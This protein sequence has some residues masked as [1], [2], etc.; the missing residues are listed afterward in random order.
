M[1]KQSTEQWLME[2]KILWIQ[3]IMEELRQPVE[4]PM[5]LYCDNNAAIIIA[6]NPVHHDWTKH[7]EIDRHFN[8]KKLE[9]GIICM[10]FVPTTQQTT[11]I[12]TKGLF[13]PNFELL[14][15]KLGMKDIYAPTWGGVSEK[16]S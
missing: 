11:C 4:A 7:V 5:K 3:R 13:K 15:G 10:P 14:I 8:K 12:L 9:V 1:P 16:S 2:C 6:H